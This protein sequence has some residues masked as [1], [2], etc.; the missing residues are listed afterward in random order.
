M[1]S[2]DSIGYYAK[3]SDR[4]SWK[5]PNQHLVEIGNQDLVPVLLARGGERKGS[6]REEPSLYRSSRTSSI[7]GSGIPSNQSKMGILSLPIVKTSYDREML[8]LR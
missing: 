1:P 3:L 6:S 4:R 2:A 5:D 7:R 8:R